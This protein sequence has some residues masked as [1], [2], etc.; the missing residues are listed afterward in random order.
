[1]GFQ[2]MSEC[3]EYGR[4]P[5]GFVVE[6]RG[7]YY[8]YPSLVSKILGIGNCHIPVEMAGG[9]GSVVKNTKEHMTDLCSVFS[10]C[11]VI[12]SL[13]LKDV[14]EGG[15]FKDCSEVL[16]Y[17][18]KRIEQWMEEDCGVDDR[19]RCVPDG[20]SIV[21]QV[22]K[23]ES[24]LLSDMRGLQESK[25]VSLS[26]EQIEDVDEMIEDPALWMRDKLNSNGKLKNPSHVKEMFSK[27]EPDEMRKN[28]KSFD[29]FYRE[30]RS[31]YEGW[32]SRLV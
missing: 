27:L 6:G 5:I 10:P 19:I 11:N 23:F 31:F 30:V 2:L 21:L 7:E 32:M 17:F 13:D 4:P 3:A 12:V 8:A 20:V 14:L 15:K 29:K 16:G 9:A 25:Y 22:K 24:W 26:D 1:M 18:N 28:S